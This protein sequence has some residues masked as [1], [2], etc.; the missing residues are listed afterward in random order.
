MSDTIVLTLAIPVLDRREETKLIRTLDAIHQLLSPTET[1]VLIQVGRPDLKDWCGKLEQHRAK[2]RVECGT[3]SGI[4][5]AMNK[6]TER[7]NGNRILF[8]GAG[9]VPLTGLQRAMERWEDTD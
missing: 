2:P 5:D 7:A 3:D 6:L 8:L 1:E 9:D 4:Y